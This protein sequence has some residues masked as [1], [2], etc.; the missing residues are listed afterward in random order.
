MRNTRSA[1]HNPSWSYHHSSKSIKR[2]QVIR[3]HTKWLLIGATVTTVAIAG[4]YIQTVKANKEVERLN[5]AATELR[6]ELQVQQD[7]KAEELRQGQDELRKQIEQKILDI[8]KRVQARN[9]RLAAKPVLPGVGVAKA[10]PAPSTQVS[11]G[12]G[13]WITAAGVTDMANAVWL[14]NKESGCR[15]SA[16]NRSSGACGIPQA[17]PCSKL[18]AARGNPVEEIKWM[19]RYVIARYGSWANAVA[20]HKSH[21]WY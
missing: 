9:A 5:Q 6:Q 10:A 7:G 3:N 8:E 12:C 13:D 2:K 1:P 18:G 21:N 19:N 4:L 16:V 20:F 14:I 15:T 11:G 17:L